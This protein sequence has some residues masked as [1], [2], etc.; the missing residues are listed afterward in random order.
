[1]PVPNDYDG[2]GRTD[3]A[4]WRPSTGV[5]WVMRSSDG[6]IVTRQWGV[7]HGRALTERLRWRRHKGHR[8]MAAFDRHVVGDQKFRRCERESSMGGIY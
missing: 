4:V 1:V 6:V 5:W 8:R 3:I 7:S 2:D